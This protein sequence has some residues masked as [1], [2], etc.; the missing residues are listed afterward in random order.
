MPLLGELGEM[1]GSEFPYELEPNGTFRTTLTSSQALVTGYAV[2]SLEQGSVLPVGTAIFQFRDDGGGLISEAGVGATLPTNRA[3]IFVDTVGT[4]TGVAIASPENGTGAITFRLLDRNGLRFRET[5]RD[6]P[7]NGHLAIFADELFA[8][9]PPGFTGVMGI[10]AEVV[11]VPITLKLT[12]NRRNDLILT[13]L[14][15]ADLTRLVEGDS[16][17]FPQIGFGLGFSTKLILISS[18][19]AEDPA[20]TGRLA[21]APL[22][23]DFEASCRGA[24]C[25]LDLRGTGL[26]M[27]DPSQHF[28][29]D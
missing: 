26:S 17:V 14:P 20:Q 3:R 10:E 4:Q 18:A 29:A 6:L 25:R 8:D 24:S 28:Q 21:R 1:V 22:P 9:L 11:I 12:V 23:A 19:E 7:P 13:T 16:L 15:I 2:V 27:G 5:T